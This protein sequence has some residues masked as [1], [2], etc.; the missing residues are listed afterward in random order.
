MRPW[1]LRTWRECPLRVCG[2]VSAVVE[3]ALGAG[4]VV[5]H[6]HEAAAVEVLAV[7]Y[8]RIVELVAATWVRAEG[9]AGKPSSVGDRRRPSRSPCRPLTAGQLCPEQPCGQTWN[10]PGRDQ[11]GLFSM[12]WPTVHREVF[13]RLVRERLGAWD[14]ACC[15]TGRPSR[16]SQLP[17]PCCERF[18]R[19]SP[20]TPV[21]AASSLPGPG[22]GST[23]G[24]RQVPCSPLTLVINSVCFIDISLRRRTVGSAPIAALQLEGVPPTCATRVR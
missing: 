7:D 1:P 8:R 20:R 11:P 3:G 19:A 13:R 24:S 18:S 4:A 15:G 5:S 23:P 17:L 9:S 2:A 22:N 14:L 6:R 12:A 10:G 16:R 21:Q